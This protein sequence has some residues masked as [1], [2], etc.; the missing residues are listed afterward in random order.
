MSVSVRELKEQDQS[1]WYEL[2][3]GYCQFYQVQVPG[4]VTEETWKRVLN[5]DRDDMYCLVAESNGNIIGFVICVI[6]PG[7]WTSKDLTYLEDLYVSETA[8]GQGAGRALID[9]VYAKAKRLNHHR[10]Y[11]RTHTDNTVARALYEKVADDSDWVM[12]EHIL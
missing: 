2:W 11:W 9:A 10:V 4:E 1:R 7:T 3:S 12:Y 5:P 8:R 6:H